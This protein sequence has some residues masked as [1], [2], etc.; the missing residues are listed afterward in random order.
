MEKYT[1]IFEKNIKNNK[2]QGDNNRIINRKLNKFRSKNTK[3]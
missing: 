2:M 1:L 3:P